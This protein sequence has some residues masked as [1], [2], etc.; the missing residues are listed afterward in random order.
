MKLTRTLLL[1]L[2]CGSWVSSAL[3]GDNAALYALLEA[4]HENG[5]IDGPTYEVIK[6]V[7]ARDKEQSNAQ[8]D[9]QTAEAV[10]AE[11]KKQ[12]E[13]Q[14]KAATADQP[15]ISTK[16]K[17]EVTSADGD[18]SVRL[19]GRIQADAAL[20]DTDVVDH[21]DGS[22][23]RRARLFMAGTLWR[24][25][26]YKFQYDFTG[27]GADG[28]ADAYVSY[29]DLGPAE[30]QVGHFKEP[31]SLQNMTSSK[32]TNFIERGLPHLLVPGRN[33]GAAVNTG[34][35]NW[36]ASAGLFGT[37]IDD[38]A[39]NSDESLGA[40]GR[41]TYAPIN[42]GNQVVH[43]GGAL[44]YRD[45]GQDKTLTFSD[46]PESHVTDIRLVNT[47]AMDADSFYRYGVEAAWVYDRLTL[48]GEY[49]GVSVDRA[50]AGNPDVDF[51]GYYAE[52]MYFLTNDQRTYSGSSGAFKSVKP[53]SAVGYGGIGAWQIGARISNVDLIDGD[54]NGG[55][56]DN[57]TLGLNWFPNANLR[58]SANYI[59]VLDTMG[60]AFAGDEPDIFTVRGQV[61]F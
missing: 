20:Y 39:G 40:T 26:D 36:S 29:A 14:V 55:E 15:T 6:Q 23:I 10:Q 24:V 16:G 45:T 48:Q 2:M 22:E 34:A 57:L 12:V 47:M 31:F 46:R 44:S 41:V 21:G 56:E 35:N 52:I 61:E 33:I 8:A 58:L 38:P 19:G 4:L 18:F 43:L 53:N 25:W 32:Y 60:G 5:T 27:S 7:A 30:I 11:V 28:I 42:N 17:F 3:A 37:G 13:E 51:D 50:V 49:M 54:I 1:L 9:A 59:K